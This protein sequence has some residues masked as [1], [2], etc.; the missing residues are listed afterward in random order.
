MAPARTE[1]IPPANEN[2]SDA[3]NLK[4]VLHE[5]NELESHVQ[6]VLATIQYPE[7][8]SLLGN[9]L[10][11]PDQ[12]PNQGLEQLAQRVVDA[13]DHVQLQL[14]PSVSLLTDGFFGYLNSKVLWTVVDARV[15]DHL[16]KNGPQSVSTLGLR[17][18]I[19]PERLSQL[20]DTLVNNGIFAYDE[21]QHTYTNNR[22]S[23][24]LRHEHWTQWHLW[25]DLYPNE[26]FNV[27]RSM[28]DAVKLG[29]SRTAAQIEYGTDLNLFEYFSQ[30]GKI[31]Q[32]QKT[33][34]AGAVAQAK[35]LVADYPWADI[36]SEQP[37]LDLGG[38]SGSF[39]ASILREHPNLV[40]GIMDLE[41]VIDL[42]TPEFRED[43]GKFADIGPRV[44]QLVVGDFLKH[45]PASAVYTM[46]WCLHDWVDDDVV[47][48]LKNVRR[49]IVASPVS[50]FVVFESIKTPGRSGRL[51]R[52]GDL[53]MM[54]T[55]NGKERSMEDW[56]RLG[57]LGGW[58]V[59]KVHQLR[60]AWPCAIDFRPV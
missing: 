50:R 34:G 41:S 59:E 21:N 22:V 52:Y 24:L 25:A 17:C 30:Q 46:K 19:Q 5:L 4:K 43:T 47:T 3:S 54:I 20:L 33:L 53:V 40:G 37:I 26:F 42:V 51:P 2:M 27:S 44:Q 60:Q 36:G 49:S 23:D 13:M 28:P 31:S 15:A 14:V 12:L 35:G 1:D 9:Q 29:E 8:A 58:R 57:K 45:I 7:I 48:I 56:D 11:D 32:F 55:C 16:A 39:L 18:G 38:G 6:R 10:H